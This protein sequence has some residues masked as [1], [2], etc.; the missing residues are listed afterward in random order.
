MTT[1]TQNIE[2]GDIIRIPRGTRVSLPWEAEKVH[3]T[4][5]ERFA[6]AGCIA[7]RDEGLSVWIRP[8]NGNRNEWVT[9]DSVERIGRLRD[10]AIDTY[11]ENP[12][13]Y[14]AAEQ[15]KANDSYLRD[16]LRREVAAWKESR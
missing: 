4:G 14:G 8:L 9:V 16:E 10:S 7:T 15:R 5:R 11:N 3:T 2:P 1:I 13:G 12:S 6:L